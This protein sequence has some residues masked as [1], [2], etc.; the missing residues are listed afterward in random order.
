MKFLEQPKQQPGERYDDYLKR[1]WEWRRLSDGWEDLKW[2][3]LRGVFWLCIIGG[4]Y[5]L[6]RSLMCCGCQP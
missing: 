2:T 3:A 4:A 1:H 6:I 5:F